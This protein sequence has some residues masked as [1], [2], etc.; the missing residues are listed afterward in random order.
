M[1]A[2]VC[3]SASGTTK[4]RIGLRPPGSS[5]SH[6]MS[7]SP[8]QVMAAVRGIGVAVMTS[9]CGALSALAFSDSRCSTPKRCCSSITA[10]ARFGA[11]KVLENAACVATTMHG[12]PLAATASTR[13][14]ADSFMPPVSSSTGMSPPGRFPMPDSPAAS[15]SPVGPVPAGS[16]PADLPPTC[17]PPSTP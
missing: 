12:V 16:P 14:R 13:R 8:N 9:R 6:E 3:A 7:R 1:L 11:W 4:V 17:A 5:V 15:P 2:M 10:S